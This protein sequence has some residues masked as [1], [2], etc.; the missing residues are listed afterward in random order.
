MNVMI[1]SVSSRVVSILGSMILSI[2]IRDN[3]LCSIAFAGECVAVQESTR[4]HFFIY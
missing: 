1:K 2:L 4:N 3:Q